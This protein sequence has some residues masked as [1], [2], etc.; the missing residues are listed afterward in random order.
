MLERQLLQNAPF[1]RAMPRGIVG[2][3]A[4]VPVHEHDLVARI[5]DAITP[6]HL[7]GRHLREKDP[8]LLVHLVDLERNG[9]H[10]ISPHHH[11]RHTVHV[12]PHQSGH[13]RPLDDDRI[14]VAVMG[15][16]EP[17][18]RLGQLLRRERAQQ[19]HVIDEVG[20]I[21]PVG[22][23]RLFEGRRVHLA[24]SDRLGRLGRINQHRASTSARHA[25]RRMG[26]HV[27]IFI[28][29]LIVLR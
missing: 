26:V 2:F 28:S 7:V 24:V 29:S 14:Q 17:L 25:D 3:V 20:R 9:L 6:L 15:H 11:D 1:H 27:A 21:V 23:H 13:R 16:I 5:D 10:A 18:D 4:G 19:G 8:A 12:L 22:R